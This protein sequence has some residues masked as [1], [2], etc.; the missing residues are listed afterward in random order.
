ME[1]IPEGLSREN[2]TGTIL[3][4]RADVY[5]YLVLGRVGWPRSWALLLHAF[6]LHERF[7]YQSKQ[8]LKNDNRPVEIATWLQ[9]A[10][11]FDRSRIAYLITETASFALFG[12]RLSAWWRTIQ[13]HK[14]ISDP[15]IHW[16]ALDVSGQ[17]GLLLVVVSLAWWG[18]V[19]HKADDESEK[20]MWYKLTGNVTDVLHVLHARQ[21]EQS[22]HSSSSTKRP[23]ADTADGPPAKKKRAPPARPAA[24]KRQSRRK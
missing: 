14:D 3:Q 21:Q 8:R 18:E 13:P 11:P 24:A 15:G 16:D 1:A 19:A 10:R 22:A 17:N 5:E 20:A 9:N 2:V 23:A 7:A 4:H 12:Q 6:V